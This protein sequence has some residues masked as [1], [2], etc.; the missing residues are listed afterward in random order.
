MLDTF[1]RG[2]SRI[3]VESKTRTISRELVSNVRELIVYG[4]PLIDFPLR[5]NV[6][7]SPRTL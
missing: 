3:E 1:R 2:A 6:S 5:R 7:V 4:T